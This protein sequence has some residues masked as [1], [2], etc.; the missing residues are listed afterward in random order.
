MLSGARLHRRLWLALDAGALV[1]V[2]PVHWLIW[3][4]LY[5]LDKLC[6]Y[7]AA[8]WVV[9][10]ALFWYLTLHCLESGIVRLP[11]G[12]SA[13][14]RDTHQMLLGAWCAAIALLVHTRFWAAT[15]RRPVKDVLRVS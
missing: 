2:V 15:P 12:V 10:I 9:S 14:V 5:E 11:R 3:Q 7:C 6:P 4:S 8:V 1:A 13:V